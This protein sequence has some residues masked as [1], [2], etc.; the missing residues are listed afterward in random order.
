[1]KHWLILL[2][3]L[4]LAAGLRIAHIDFNSLTFD[5][6]WHLELST[7]RGSP[8]VRLPQDVVIF[9]APAVTSL[10]AAPPWHAVWTHMDFVVHP[11]LYCTTLR[12][13][14][15]IF[16]EG[17]SAARSVSIV[18]SLIAIAL[19]FFVGRM[20]HGTWPATGAVLLMGV[21]P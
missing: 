21:A 4:L 3:I 2:A 18:C 12:L 1:M 13:W 10:V 9:D 11:P 15:D 20:L 17:D 7:G 16:G 8:H 14:R 19:T 6:Q 5:E